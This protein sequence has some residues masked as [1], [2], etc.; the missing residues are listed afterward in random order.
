MS[1]II[2]PPIVSQQLLRC[3]AVSPVKLHHLGCEDIASFG[4]FLLSNPYERSF[5]LP[6]NRLYEVKNGWSR[7]YVYNL[8]NFS[9]VRTKEF[10]LV[11]DNPTRVLFV[12]LCHSLGSEN[13]EA[14]T[15]NETDEL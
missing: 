9:R 10:E 7:F 6:W 11:L 12:V 2:F 14:S 5:L 8:S 3:W 1:F 15:V 4:Y 13:V